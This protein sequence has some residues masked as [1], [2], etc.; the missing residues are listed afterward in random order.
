MLSAWA[1]KRVLFNVCVALAMTADPSSSL[2][3]SCR[4]SSSIKKPLKVNYRNNVF[5]CFLEQ[6]HYAKKVSSKWMS[7]ITWYLEFR[8]R[9]H[10]KILSFLRTFHKMIF[11]QTQGTREIFSSNRFVFHMID[12]SY[13]RRGDVLDV[14]MIWRGAFF[15]DSKNRRQGSVRTRHSDS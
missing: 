15:Y 3:M 8:H 14:Q 9:R 6:L 4:V 11:S 2:Y 7:W 5:A 12:K 13:G 10:N 1:I